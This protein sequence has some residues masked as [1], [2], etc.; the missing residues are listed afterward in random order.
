MP[1][2]QQ[3]ASRIGDAPRWGNLD[4]L[5]CSPAFEASWLQARHAQRR[6]PR[7]DGPLGPL[8]GVARVYLLHFKC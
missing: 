8:A 4:E 2:M 6:R 5:G 3:F 7:R 1:V